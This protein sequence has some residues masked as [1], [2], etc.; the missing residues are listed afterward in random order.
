MWDIR[1]RP[2]S[3]PHLVYQWVA[4]KSSEVLALA[5]HAERQVI[6]TAGNDCVI[7]VGPMAAR[8]TCLQ[9]H[10]LWPCAVQTGQ[11]EHTALMKHY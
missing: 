2:A 8:C 11:K 6:M 10:L 5:Y 1:R 3:Q 9:V 7:K 4:H